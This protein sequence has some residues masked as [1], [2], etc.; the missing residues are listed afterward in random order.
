MVKIKPSPRIPCSCQDCTGTLF[1]VHAP[2]RKEKHSPVARYSRYTPRTR[3]LCDDC[4][5]DIHAR[6]VQV[7]PLPAGVRWRR[8]VTGEAPMHLCERHKTERHERE[9]DELPER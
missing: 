7:A 5:R 4:I 1:P 6:G 3:T 2:D 8:S 9:T